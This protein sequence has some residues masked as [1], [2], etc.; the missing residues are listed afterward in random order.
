MSM[1]DSRVLEK[2]MSA[3]TNG[4]KQQVTW[5][6]RLV[7]I[8]DLADHSWFGSFKMFIFY[9]RKDDVLGHGIFNLYQAR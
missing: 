1:E 2:K 9:C 5:P 8:F 4:Q 3:T 7:A 6:I